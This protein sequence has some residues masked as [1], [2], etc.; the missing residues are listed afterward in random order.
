MLNKLYSIVSTGSQAPSSPEKTHPLALTTVKVTDI[1][2]DKVSLVA[3]TVQMDNKKK[4]KYFVISLMERSPLSGKG[5]QRSKSYVL[6]ML[7]V[8]KYQNATNIT[9]HKTGLI[10]DNIGSKSYVLLIFVDIYI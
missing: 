2:I 1:V 5:I 3:F 8:L 7:A 9:R 10:I 6:W 4:T